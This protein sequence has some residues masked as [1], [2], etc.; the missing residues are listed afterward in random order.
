M[1]IFIYVMKSKRSCFL[2]QTAE[3]N[4]RDIVYSLHGNQVHMFRTLFCH[5][6]CYMDSEKG[7]IVHIFSSYQIIS[8]SKRHLGPL[9]LL[10]YALENSLSIMELQDLLFNYAC[11]LL[12]ACVDFN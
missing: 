3:V 11:I 12:H 9:Q 1:V 6:D 8:I 10:S 7:P 5:C 2:W 4:D